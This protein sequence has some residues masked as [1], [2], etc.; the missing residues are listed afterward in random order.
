MVHL[1]LGEGNGKPLQYPCLEN[2]MDRGAWWTAVHGVAK[3]RAQ[4]SD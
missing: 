2:F 4:L 3:S 1:F